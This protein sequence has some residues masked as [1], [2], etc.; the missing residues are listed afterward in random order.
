MNIIFVDWDSFC[1]ADVCSALKNLDHRVYVTHLTKL[2]ES[3]EDEEFIHALR[4]LIKEDHCELVISMNFFPSISI[5]CEEMHCPYIAWIY[6]N[7]QLLAYDKTITN[8]CNHIYTFDSHMVTQL[9][10]KGIETMHYAPLAANVARLTMEELTRQQFEQYQCDISFVGS[11]YNEA[12][13]FYSTLLS[14]AN[15]PYL[16]GYLEGILEAQKKVHGYNFIAECLTADI[17]T[18]IQKCMPQ[19]PTKGSFLTPSDM[20]AD[21]FLAKRLAT[22]DR[23][24]L[25]HVLG[26]FFDV[27]LYTHRQTPLTNITHHGTIDYYTEMPALFR[28]SKINLNCTKR[29]IK[30]GIP[31]RA[32]DIMGCG[33]FL[34]SNFQE[35]FL[36]HFEPGVHFTMYSSMEEAVDICQYYLSHEEE[37]RKIMF[38]ALKIMSEEHTFEFRLTQMINML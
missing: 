11:L 6:S 5:A 2:A 32:M 22:I 12:N 21:F 23:I 1:S 36:M 26:N 18:S 8:E 19:Q 10:A 13:D 38:N 24:E 15:N 3:A 7:P 20:Y 25:L 27:H 29:S 33:G 4:N 28:I 17:I 9:Q 30:H 14:R 37:R 16:Q 31:L 34:L 35:D